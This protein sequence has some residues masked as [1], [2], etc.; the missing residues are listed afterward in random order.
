MIAFFFRNVNKN[1]LSACGSL[2]H[3]QEKIDLMM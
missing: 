3:I 1:I 2:A